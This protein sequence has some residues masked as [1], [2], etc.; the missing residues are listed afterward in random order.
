MLENYLAVKPFHVGL[1]KLNVNEGDTVQF[2]PETNQFQHGPQTAVVPQIH[3]MIEMGVLRAV[4]DKELKERAAAR[5]AAPKAVHVRPGISEAQL[6]KAGMNPEVIDMS[7]AAASRP[8]DEIRAKENPLQKNRE[9]LDTIK[10]DGKPWPI[11]ATEEKRLEVLKKVDAYDSLLRLRRFYQL[12]GDTKFVLA[13]QD[14]VK[15]IGVPPTGGSEIRNDADMAREVVK[16]QPGPD[17]EK[18]TD[19]GVEVIERPGK[20]KKGAPAKAPPPPAKKGNKVLPVNFKPAQDK[21]T[22]EYAKDLAR[23][24]QGAGQPEPE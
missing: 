18:L 13:I 16:K 11:H 4:T 21:L 19:K 7:S 24:P 6:R 8:L 1:L 10:V 17:L 3:A 23:V 15:E 22:K 5:A 20:A 12:A 9:I 2:D 14:Q